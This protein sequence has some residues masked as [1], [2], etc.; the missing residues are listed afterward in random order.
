MQRQD[1]D[2][3]FCASA[4]RRCSR[5]KAV[6]ENRCRCWWYVCTRRGY[7]VVY[8]YI[9]GDDGWR[10]GT[11]EGMQEII[12]KNWRR[13]RYG[14]IEAF[15]VFFSIKYWYHDYSNHSSKPGRKKNYKHPSFIGITSSITNRQIL[16]TW[17]KIE[18]KKALRR[19]RFIHLCKTRAA[20]TLPKLHTPAYTRVI[21]VH[22]PLYPPFDSYIYERVWC[23]RACLDVPLFRRT[24]HASEC[25][26]SLAFYWYDGHVERVRNYLN[27]TLGNLFVRRADTRAVLVYIY[28]YM[29]EM[30]VGLSVMREFTS[31]F[32]LFLERRKVCES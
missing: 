13:I 31:D 25:I 21:Y 26:P 15:E 6:S 10:I 32:C 12:G 20:I 4:Q 16:I 1:R 30:L 11:V 18:L 2:T 7:A 19:R 14:W 23:S 22:T 9:V 27:C 3:L 24:R 17:Q 8:V 28:T 5:I 29:V